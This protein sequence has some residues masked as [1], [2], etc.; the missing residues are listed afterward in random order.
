MEYHIETPII[1]T[2]SVINLFNNLIQNKAIN[3]KKLYSLNNIILENNTIDI[4]NIYCKNRTNKNKLCLNKCM[5]YSKY[6]KI[7]DPVMKEQKRINRLAMNIR[8]R[9]LKKLDKKLIEDENEEILKNKIVEEN[10]IMEVPSAPTYEEIKNKE[11]IIL[12]DYDQ[13][14]DE[15]GS[16]IKNII[17][18][19]SIYNIDL[20]K[21]KINMISESI[22]KIHVHT[23]RHYRNILMDNYV[24]INNVIQYRNKVLLKINDIKDNNGNI[25]PIVNDLLLNSNDNIITTIDDYKNKLENINYDNYKYKGINIQRLCKSTIELQF[26]LL[27][28]KGSNTNINS[29]L[30]KYIN[31]I[32]KRIP[33]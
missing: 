30:A 13:K 4:K 3:I 17:K 21:D 20:N 18:N 14:P 9:E 8:R 33:K 1:L 27:L 7:H 24:E 31:N 6:C 10:K 23:L 19:K 25:L 16:S 28:A 15:C 11:S 22:N 2:T 26:K 12:P 32:I 5:E 29:K